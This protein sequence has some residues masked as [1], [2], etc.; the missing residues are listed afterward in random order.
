MANRARA[1]P[2]IAEGEPRVLGVPGRRPCCGARH[3]V[4][5][6]EWPRY[7]PCRHDLRRRG[8]QRARDRRIRTAAAPEAEVVAR[9]AARC[10]RR[11]LRTDR[12]ARRRRLLLR[13]EAGALAVLVRRSRGLDSR[14]HLALPACA[15]GGVG[16]VP[17]RDP[18]SPETSGGRVRADRARRVAAALALIFAAAAVLL[19][20]AVAIQRFPAGLS[21]LACLAAAAVAAWWAFLH[22]GAARAAAATLAFALLASAIALTAVERRPLADVVIFVCVGL[23]LAAARHAFAV[24]ASLPAA[25]RPSRPVLFYNPKSGG[26]KAERSN[27][28]AE[29]RE[30]GIEPRKLDAG[31]DLALLVEDAI[32]GGAD[33]LAMAGGD[34]SQ[35]VVAA[36]AAAHELPYACI[37]AGTRNHFALDLGVD[38]NDVVG[39]LDAFVDG[40]GRLVDLAAV[41]GRTFVNNVS[42]GFYPEAV[43][44]KG[45]RHPQI[46]TK[47]HPP[48]AGL[49]D[50]GSSGAHGR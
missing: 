20:L 12:D 19:A 31:D 17:Q 40:R 45:Y 21:V 33:A 1:S 46:P 49:R 10:C 24:R 8:L 23:S 13:G 42:L 4:G 18:R 39:A 2:R 47:P 36:A 35:A 32:R 44:R 26:G 27:L 48:P 15:G 38:R 50:Q 6:R 14:P 22:R 9:S 28:A 30:R 37:P 41:N 5:A 29:A 3:G 11:R 34:G 43:G 7:R 25:P 16:N